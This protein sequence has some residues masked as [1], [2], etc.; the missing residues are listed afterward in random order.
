MD[1]DE[2]QYHEVLIGIFRFGLCWHP[3]LLIYV[4]HLFL[5]QQEITL[6]CGNKPIQLIL[7]PKELSMQSLPLRL[8]LLLIANSSLY[9][10]SF[11]FV[12]YDDFILTLHPGLI[13]MVGDMHHLAIPINIL[14]S[15]ILIW[16][17]PVALSNYE[18]D[19][20]NVFADIGVA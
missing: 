7:V 10:F 1:W 11:H 12:L 2:V 6:H 15:L 14:Q 13:E 5:L 20:P 8:Q 9:A 18:I 17:L 4:S 19:E 16:G 3:Y